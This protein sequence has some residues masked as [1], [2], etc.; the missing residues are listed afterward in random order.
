MLVGAVAVS[1]LLYINRPPSD[2]AE[3]VHVPVTVDVAEVVK[4]SLRIPVQAQGTVTPLQATA[5][6]AEVSTQEPQRLVPLS[7]DRPQ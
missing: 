6:R 1:G 5:L 2:I 4:Q 3:P 7:E